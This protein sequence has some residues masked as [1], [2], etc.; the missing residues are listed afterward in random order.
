ML[1]EQIIKA[2]KEQGLTQK[3]LALKIGVRKATISDFETGKTA[4]GSDILEKIINVLSI[5]VMKILDEKK[6]Q[7]ELSKSIANILVTNYNINIKQ[8]EKM[9]RDEIYALTKELGD[10]IITLPVVSENEY[11]KL[12]KIDQD[13][14]TWNLF[15]TLLKLDL[16]YQN[17]IS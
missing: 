11:K 7:L 1:K 14:K 2:R 16:I 13:Y 3:D 17:R 6:M 10:Y 12:E 4:L 9:T 8:L 5:N 15:F